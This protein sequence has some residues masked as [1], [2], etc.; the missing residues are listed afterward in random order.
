MSLA[1]ATPADRADIE[2][3]LRLVDLTVSGLDAPS[4]HLWVERDAAGAVSATTGF[5][6]GADGRNVLIRS[7]AVHPAARGGGRGTAL[8]RRAIDEAAA[9]RASR[10]WL[11]SRRSGPFWQGLGFAPAD[12]DELAAVL[13]DAHQV[14][15]FR[16]TGQLGREVAWS[17][18][19][20]SLST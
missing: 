9:H 10:A 16:A 8:A 20:D 7:V 14:R 2:A 12:R 6:Q 5:E 18:P 11:F 13:S 19:L 1:P 17:M 3:F 4:V 15:L